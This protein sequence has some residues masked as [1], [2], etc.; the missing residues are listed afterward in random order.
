MREIVVDPASLSILLLIAGLTIST[1]VLALKEVRARAARPSGSAAQEMPANKPQSPALSSESLSSLRQM[2]SWLFLAAALVVVLIIG[3]AFLKDRV[4]QVLTSVLTAVITTLVS[5]F[6]T[7]HSSAASKGQKAKEELTRYGLLAWR[8][9][10]SLQLKVKEQSRLG[11]AIGK[12]TLEAWLLDIDD[13]KLAWQDLLRETFLLQQR[14]QIEIS[15]FA[16]EYA[17]KL[18]QARPEDRPRLH[19]EHQAELANLLTQ[20]PLPVRIPTEVQCP[21]CGASV[22]AWIGHNSGD[23]HTLLCPVCRRRFH[24]HWSC[25]D[26]VDG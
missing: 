8:N 11:Q 9:L 19:A 21:N 7:Y 17:E 25:P 24:S 10:N 26:S 16:R 13:A 12:E 5:V 23:S 3:G 15:E 14:L 22:T 6:A 4:A 2:R 20:A 18:R 1:V